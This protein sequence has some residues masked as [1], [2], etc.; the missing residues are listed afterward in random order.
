M[1]RGNIQTESVVR[2]QSAVKHPR[3]SD[4]I[5]EIET[6]KI[7]ESPNSMPRGN[8]QT[9]SAVRGVINRALKE[10]YVQHAKLEL[11]FND[12]PFYLIKTTPELKTKECVRCCRQITDDYVFTH[13][14]ITQSEQTVD[15]NGYATQL[16]C[17]T[18]SCFFI[19]YPYV[20]PEC[21]I[22]NVP[23]KI[24]QEVISKILF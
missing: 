22:N 21:I 18:F 8:I 2:V 13:F 4:S 3:L 7:S 16:I 23:E 24:A 20:T 6:K 11:Y 9:E 10:Y 19:R 12:Y 5:P 17:P 14:E 1:P 15:S